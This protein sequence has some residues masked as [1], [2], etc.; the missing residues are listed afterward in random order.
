[1]IG[2]R[3]RTAGQPYIKRKVPENLNVEDLKRW[4]AAERAR[5]YRSK[6][7]NSEKREQ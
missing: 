6:I 1:M 3:L 4:K 5:K 2:G 7:A